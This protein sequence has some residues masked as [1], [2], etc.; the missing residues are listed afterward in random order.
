MRGHG[1]SIGLLFAVNRLHVNPQTLVGRVSVAT[2]S[3]HVLLL[4]FQLV[5]W[6]HFQHEVVDVEQVVA[7]GFHLG[8]TP[9]TFLAYFSLTNKFRS[10]FLT[11]I[12]FV[13]E[14][15][16]FV[17]TLSVLIKYIKRIQ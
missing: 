1:Q 13:I 11:A 9:A 15:F 5:T 17:G 3:A 14:E 12:A 7:K 10:S 2:R 6:L 16:G 4:V 8:E